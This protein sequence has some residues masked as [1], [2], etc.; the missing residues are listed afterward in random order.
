ML[1]PNS[2]RFEQGARGWYHSPY[3]RHPCFWKLATK[4]ATQTVGVR[5][6]LVEKLISGVMRWLDK[7]SMVNSTMAVLN[8]S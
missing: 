7:V 5:K 1:S 4:G 3:P 8:P 6:E 2:A